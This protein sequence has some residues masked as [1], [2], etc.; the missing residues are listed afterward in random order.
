ME[1]VK[2]S[3]YN[4]IN[5]EILALEDRGIMNRF[6][7]FLLK[8]RR[9]VF[10]ISVPNDLYQRAEVL[11][12]DIFQ[13]RSD[14]KEY[15]QSELVEHVFLDFIDEVRNN[16]SNV[17]SIYTRLNVRKQQ[18]PMVNDNPLLPSKSNTTVITKI[19]RDDVLR[20]E[21]LLQ[22]LSYFVPKHGMDVEQLIEI[23]YLD[24][25]LEYTKGRRKNVIKDILEYLEG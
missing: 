23:V 21:V 2:Y 10:K 13:K 8:D 17:G 5:R 6:I 4:L 3:R 16:D 7:N 14:D 9:L 15:K 11:C 18:L 22:D 24:F 20:A 19:D 25:L 1:G 12:D